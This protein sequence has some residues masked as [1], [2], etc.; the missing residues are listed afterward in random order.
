MTSLKK[1]LKILECL[2][3][4]TLIILSRESPKIL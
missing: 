4:S 1:D 3:H 2:K